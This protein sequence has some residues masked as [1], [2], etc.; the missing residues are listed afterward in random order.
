MY[1]PYPHQEGCLSAVQEVRDRGIQ[2][3]LVVMATGLG[4]TVTV[5]FD[6]KRWRE[7]YET[8]RVLFLCHNNDILHQAK[9]TFEAV[10]GS[11]STYGYF[12][13]E[14]KH[15]HRTDFLFASFQTMERHR[16]LFNSD[17]FAYI[18]VDESHHSQ[19]NTFRSTVDYFRPKFL[20]GVTAT[21]D[22]LDELDIRE[23]FGKEV[24]YLPLE[25][26]MARELVTPVDYRLLT[27]EIQLSGIIDTG[28]KRISLAMLNSKVF[29]PKRDEE[30]AK[31]ITR[32]VS[33]L[34]NPRVIVFCQSIKHCEHLAAH[35]PNSFA[36]HSRVPERERAVKLEMFRQGFIGTV[37]TVDAFNEGIDIPQANVV[38][39]LRSTQSHTI[40]LQ[41]LG[42]GLR[43]SDG[44]DK[45]LVLD[46][47]ANCERV[48]MVHTLWRMVDDASGRSGKDDKKRIEPMTLNVDSVE[49]AERI[50]PLLKLMEKIRPVMVS[51]IPLLRDEYSAKNP[52]PSNRAVAGSGE[53]Y[54]WLCSTC[55]YE[56]Q[57]KGYHRVNGSGCPACAGRVVTPANNL[58]AKYPALAREYSVR[59]EL[60]ANQMVSGTH[61]KVWWKCSTCQHEWQANVDSRTSRGTGCPGC[62]GTV[63]T[64][65][66]NLAVMNPE[67]AKEYSSRNEAPSASISPKSSGKK[68]WWKCSI[69]GHEWKATP[70]SRSSGNGCPACA[71][72][73]V[74]THNNLAASHYHLV[75]EYS[76]RNLL[77]A[78]QVLPGSRNKLWWKCRDCGNEWE[79]T[80]YHRA[81]GSG[82][83][84]CALA[85][86]REKKQQNTKAI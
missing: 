85:Q 58:E 6:T 69:C 24:Y 1:I 66:N 53:K 60:P 77:P 40:F 27:D 10:N 32:H 30:I 34:I 12:Y 9:T 21:P 41:Q 11:G 56:W 13:G 83:Q 28:H 15:L 67:L 84:K 20:L 31:I 36:I 54:W 42:R 63:V 26:A 51:E 5:A 18:V 55:G 19:A 37:L 50:V 78:D 65:S 25:E 62:A 59:N 57:A 43:K 3:A 68:V 47:V 82:C 86:I 48:K 80:A 4:K 49:F 22:R 61:K 16:H 73:V 17:E 71:N 2:R 39:F 81:K 72:R 74:S 45:V 35:I 33:G 70:C 75:A 29:I 79:A 44:K 8:G 7:R 23:I 46:F 38:V 14:E 52:I 64:T 76:S